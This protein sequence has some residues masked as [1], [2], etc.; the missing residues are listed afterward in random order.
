LED[1][2]QRLREIDREL[3]RR[4]VRYH[5]EIA[6]RAPLLFCSVGLCLGIVVARYAPVAVWVWLLVAGVSGV[7]VLGMGAAGYLSANNRQSIYIVEYIALICFLS[8]GAVR[9]AR[10]H[11]CAPDDIASFVGE[12]ERL[13]ALRGVIVTEPYANRR[14][15]WLFSRFRFT[16]PGSSFY[17]AVNEIETVDGWRGGRGT[18]RVQVNQPVLDLHGG[19]YVQVYCLLSRFSSAT[20]P[21]E[22]DMAAHMHSRG[23]RVA[24]TV[25]MR[26]AIELLEPP[27]KG[28]YS[29]FRARLRTW[30][31]EGLTGGMEADEQ[32]RAMLEA[33]LLGFRGNID[34]QTYTAFRKTGLLHFIS[35]SGMHLGILIWV[36]WWAGK[37]VGL[38]HRGRAFVCILA[39]CV[40]LMVVPPRPPTLRAAVIALV[41][42]VSVFFVRRPNMVNT[43]ALAA[44]ILLLSKPMSLFDA[45]FQLSFASVLGIVMF[46]ERINSFLGGRLLPKPSPGPRNVIISSLSGT[47]RSI[48]SLFS[49]GVAAWLGGA[50]IMLYYFHTVTA[51]TSVWTVLVFPLV[52]VILVAGLVKIVLSFLLPT[53]ASVLAILLGGIVRVLIGIVGFISHVVPS[54][55]L[56]GHVPLLMVLGYYVLVLTFAFAYFRRPRIK[57]ALCSSLVLVLF[58]WLGGLRWARTMPGDLQLTVLDVGHGQAIVADLPGRGRFLFDCGSLDV[59]DAGTR[60]AVPFIRFSGDDNIDYVVLS[61]GDIDHINGVAEVTQQCRCRRVV[62]AGQLTE[63][64]KRYGAEKQLVDYLV[65]GGFRIAKDIDSSANTGNYVRVTAIWPLEG[66][67]QNQSNPNDESMAI[68]IE[69]AGRTILLC[70]DIEAEGQHGLLKAYPGLR[71]DVV[72]TP[73]HGSARTVD[74]Q[75]LPALRPEVVISSCGRTAYEKH[76]LLQPPPDS[77]AFWTARDGAVTV[78]INRSGNITVT[79]FNDSKK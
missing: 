49:V 70:S 2:R 13:A 16:D 61:H 73:H 77:K 43:L 41:Y 4:E 20:N 44:I 38:L 65:A 51:L 45:G 35:L 63:E 18:V 67:G 75:F 32:G 68:L 29:R 40:F 47:S 3:D 62:A 79:T 8:L 53:A 27:N 12:H 22:F 21:G 76:R 60:I 25:K 74:Q 78:R 46:A 33:L 66:S 34:S 11:Y 52:A 42:C 58:V 72:V 39:I 10:F 64:A 56:V 71:A 36:V 57:A 5:R 26:E 23:V 37:S 1:I 6:A 24:A 48:V 54:E 14:G 9:T 30:A 7:A 28:L 19:D 31:T 15:D 50:G 59:S 55:F 69:Y 17:L